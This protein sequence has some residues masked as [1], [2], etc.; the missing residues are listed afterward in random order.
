MMTPDLKRQRWFTGTN[1][2]PLR[3]FTDLILGTVSLCPC[4]HSRRL[5]IHIP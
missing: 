2:N 5:Q 4:Q 3:G 1:A